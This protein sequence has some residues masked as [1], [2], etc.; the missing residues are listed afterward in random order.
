MIKLWLLIMIGFSAVLYG[1]SLW[2]NG[3]EIYRLN[4]K[5]GDIIKIKFSDTMIMNYKMEAKLNNYQNIKGKKGS[6]ELF[7]FFPNAQVDE[8]DNARN[9][10]NF[11]V[12]NVNKFIIPAKITG[13]DN[14][15]VAIQGNNSSLINGEIV[16]INI[17]GNFPL[18]SLSADFSV[19]SSDIY[20]LD[21]KL[22]NESPAENAVFNEND[23]AFQTNFTEI[24]TNQVI[25]NQMIDTNKNV[26]NNGVFT[27]IVVSTNM[28]AF[29]LE[30]KG[31]QDTKKKEIMIN[32][33]NFIIQA[34]FR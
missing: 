34:L 7:S 26:T 25:T 28:S 13:I 1:K 20:N 27:N 8:N 9:Q 15:M 4:V 30:F 17:S 24:T 19:L 6:G 16:K 32:Y 11:T 3:S 22:Q 14:G 10:N 12:N 29:K 21:F 31:I 23:L 18:D 5:E 33:I 2:N